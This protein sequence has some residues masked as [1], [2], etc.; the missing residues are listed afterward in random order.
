MPGSTPKT[1]G[2]GRQWLRLRRFDDRRCAAFLCGV[3]EVGR[4]PLAGPVVA[5]AVILPTKAQL[6]GTDDSKRLR[7]AERERLAQAGYTPPE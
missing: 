2:A 3:D 4:G 1:R 5:A 6:P 7:A